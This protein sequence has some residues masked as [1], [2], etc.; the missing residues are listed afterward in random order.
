MKTRNSII[1]ALVLGLL[2]V[3]P[4]AIAAL[5]ESQFERL[6]QAFR[7]T[8]TADAVRDAVDLTNGVVSGG[9]SAAE[10]DYLDI[11]AAGAAEGSKALVL[12]SAKGIATVTTITAGNYRKAIYPSVITASAD[13]S[14]TTLRAYSY[15]RVAT[16]AG[17][18][19]L[20]FSDSAFVAADRGSEWIFTVEGG[21]TN[22]LTVTAGDAGV[23]TIK[24]VEP[25]GTTCEDEGDSITV[26]L[27]ST[28]SATIIKNCAD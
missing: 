14:T 1:G 24:T 18:V 8:E 27:Y 10:L 19:D 6:K 13:V 15:F 21:G 25:D 17:A 2:V 4:S 3:A 23:T 12:D 22:A 26:L 9:L 20:D 11:A 7:D 28:G 5:T 16:H